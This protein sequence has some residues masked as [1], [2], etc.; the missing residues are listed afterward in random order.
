MDNKLDQIDK[1][2]LECFELTSQYLQLRDQ[3]Q[4]KLTSA[5]LDLSL[6]QTIKGH[7]SIS[8]NQYDQRTKA[9]ITIFIDESKTFSIN[10]KTTDQNK[11]NTITEI[12]QPN[13]TTETEQPK[14]R[15][16]KQKVAENLKSDFKDETITEKL[17]END[18]KPKQDNNNIAKKQ[19][20]PL[21]WFGML[22][23]Q[24]LRN[25]QENFSK[26]LKDIL[27]LTRIQIEL[28]KKI[29]ESEN[30]IKNTKN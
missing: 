1:S 28:E 2:Y 12:E 15:R 7:H 30:L 5:F 23:C 4:Q 11:P 8:K 21:F 3:L 26:S 24:P 9:S 16:R 25:S 13:T 14:L 19:P 27:E 20:N 10:S 17:D 22:P 29:I 6:A 18:A